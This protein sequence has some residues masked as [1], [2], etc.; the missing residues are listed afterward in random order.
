MDAFDKAIR[1]VKGQ[2]VKQLS[3]TEFEVIGFRKVHKVI[4]D[5]GRVSCID[6]E[7]F[8]IHGVKMTKE[9]S[10]Y[11]KGY[12]CSHIIATIIFKGTGELLS[13]KRKF[14]KQ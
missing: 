4:L 13:G 2:C 6:C 14:E 7:Y 12:L 11:T 5:A 3:D 9:T 10:G 1:L 8:A